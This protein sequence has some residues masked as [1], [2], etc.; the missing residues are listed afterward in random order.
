MPTKRD[1]YEILEVERNASAS[2]LKKAYRKKAVKYHPDKNPDDPSAEEKF[3]ELGEAY[4]ALSDPQKRAAY[5]RYGHAAFQANSSGS[6]GF[7]DAADIFNQVFGSAFGFGD[8]FGGGRRRRDPSG[9]TRGSDLRYDMPI[10]LEDAASG[11]EKEIEVEKYGSCKKCNGSGTGKDGSL[12]ICNT[13]NGHGH[14]ISSRGFFQVQQPCP[15]CHGAGQ[16]ISNPCSH[17]DGDGRVQITSKVKIKIPAG[18]DTGNRL[19]VSN[20]GDVG[21][22]G[23]PAGDLYVVIHLTEHDIFERHGDDLHAHVPITFPRA[24]LGGEITVPTLKSTATIRV[25]AGTQHGTLFRL[26][27][28]GMPI[29]SESNH[30]GDLIIHLEVE[31]PSKLN[32]KQKELLEE[33]AESMGEE[34][35]PL[36]ESFF[37]KAKRFFKD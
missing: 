4:E 16:I 9:R 17:C 35:S 25:P 34:N 21:L 2:D 28:K 3:K 5:D 7:H 27:G 26:R 31:V 24:A 15:T 29:L 22:R 8:M 20:N 36:H 33:L 10:T 11:V 12:N 13:C 19:R 1:Y 32:T 23:G 37:A 14:V 6:G 30:H 18:V